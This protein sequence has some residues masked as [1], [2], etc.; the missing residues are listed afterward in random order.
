MTKIICTF[1]LIVS[2]NSLL[3]QYLHYWD[4]S[5][6]RKS[7]QRV[8]NNTPIVTPKTIVEQQ[9]VEAIILKPVFVQPI[10]ALANPV[11]APVNKIETVPKFIINSV[12]FH[13]WP[14]LCPGL[15][16]SIPVLNNYVPKEILIILKEKFK[17]H[18]YS[19]SSYKGEDNTQ[20]YKLKV[21]ANGM[22]KYEYASAKG[23]VISKAS[24]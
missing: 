3:A 8:E 1:F 9:K 10:N 17:G 6:P 14:D 13:E 5:R 2:T 4:D 21:C 24:D 20:E 7:T 19:I 11:Y 16:G 15:A 22:I 18:L 12:A 23:N